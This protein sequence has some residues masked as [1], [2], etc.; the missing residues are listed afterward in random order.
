M[1]SPLKL[2][3]LSADLRQAETAMIDLGLDDESIRDTLEGLALPFE[4]T[5][6]GCVAT[7]KNI[8]VYAKAKKERGQELIAEAESIEKRVEWL[9]DYVLKNMISVGISKIESPSFTIV[10]KENPVAVVIDSEGAIPQEYM[11]LPD[12]PAMV[13]NKK[14]ISEAIKAGMEVPGCHLERAKAL[15]IK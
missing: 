5:A 13:P 11:R 4:E 15:K 3:E 6:I 14:L 1:N 10:V 12:P 9:K 2:Y 7:L 8:E